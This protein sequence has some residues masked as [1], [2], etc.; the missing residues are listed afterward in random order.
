LSIVRIVLWIVLLV[1]VWGLLRPRLPRYMLPTFEGRGDFPLPGVSVAS[2]MISLIAFNL[3]FAVQ[4]ML[5]IAYFSGLAQM[6]RDMTMA[7]Y[8]HRGAYPLIATALL[9]AAFV[10]VTLRPGSATAAVPA[11]RWLVVLWIGQNLLLVAFSIQRTIDYIQSYSLTE[12]RIAALAWM[13]LVAF[14]LVSICWRMLRDRSA[15]WLINVNMAAAA[16]VLTVASFVDLGEVSA[17]WNVRHAREAGGQGVELDLCYLDSLGASA[18]LPLM[19]LEQRADLKASFR[20][21]VQAVRERRFRELERDVQHGW[22]TLRGQ[23]RLEEARTALGTFPQAPLVPGDRG[24]DGEIYPPSEYSPVAPPA[25]KPVAADPVATPA[26]A[27]AL[28]GETRK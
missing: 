24:C 3:L 2:V 23:R 15:G 1:T 14:G 19:T 27:P 25:P 16:L 21:K 9:A 18:L 6:P 12:L 5:D 4:N 13:V 22:W 11:I 26:S 17:S 20:E 8:A 10:L 7:Q 28:T